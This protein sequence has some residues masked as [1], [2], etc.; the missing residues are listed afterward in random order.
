MI[1]HS[2]VFFATVS[3]ASAMEAYMAMIMPLPGHSAEGTTIVMVE[4]G[5]TSVFYGGHVTGLES[6]LDAST[7]DAMNGCGLHLHVGSSCENVT[8]QGGHLYETDEDP[9][10]E[11]RH[12]TS[13]EGEL[14]DGAWLEIGT[15]DVNGKVVIGKFFCSHGN[16]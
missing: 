6:S 9:W 2:L 10:L 4:E 1:F 3:A 12:S 5:S 14:L 7:C 11:A 16:F 8:T 13:A 15:N